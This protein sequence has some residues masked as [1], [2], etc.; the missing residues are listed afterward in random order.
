MIVKAIAAND[1]TASDDVNIEDTAK[2][3]DDEP[4]KENNDESNDVPDSAT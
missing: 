1:N 4:E 3:K 2:D